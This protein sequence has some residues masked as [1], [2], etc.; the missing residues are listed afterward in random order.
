MLER[1]CGLD[2]IVEPTLF[3]GSLHRWSPVRAVVRSSRSMIRKILALHTLYGSIE[4]PY[5]V[6]SYL[7]AKKHAIKVLFTIGDSFNS[8]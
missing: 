6:S 3:I 4:I 2:C 5:T 8:P 7:V 1:A